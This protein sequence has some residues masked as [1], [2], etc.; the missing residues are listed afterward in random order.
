MHG[1]VLFEPP[2]PIQQII[3]LGV[4]V[5]L[6]A[7]VSYAFATGLPPGKRILLVLLRLLIIAGIVVVLCRPM[8]VKPA[9]ESGEKPVFTVLVDTSASM[10]TKDEG[11]ESRL[12]A[13]AAA[14]Q[15]A[16]GTFEGE[17]AQRYQVNFEEFSEEVRASSFDEIVRRETAAG[18]KT[19]IATALFGVSS[20]GPGKK[21][22]GV[23]LISD[24]RDNVGGEVE[25]V[26]AH[27]RSQK[28]PVW[29]TPVGSVTE[30]KD[31]YVTARLNQNF[32][33]V[34]QPANIKVELSQTGYKNWYAKVNL[35]REDKYVTT[36]QVNL[37]EGTTALDIPIKED[38]KGVFRYSVAV[39][40]L[41]GEADVKNNRRSVFVRVVDEKPK[42][43]LVEAEPYWDTRFLLRA[44][45]ADPNLEVSSLFQLNPT[46]V[47][48]IQ[49]KTS[50]DSLEKESVKTAF[51]M[52]RTKEDLYQYDC[53]ILG[54]GIDA[55][56]DSEELKLLRDY[57]MDRG[58]SIVFAR[59][60]SYSGDRPEIANIEP[61]VWDSQ[62]IKDV[63]FELTSEGRMNP[64]FTFDGKRAPD[65]VIRE[66]PS[67]VSVTKIQKEKSL[68][69]ILAKSKAGT[70]AQEMAVISYQRYGKGKVM[71]IGSAGLW[72]WAFMPESFEQYDDVYQLFWRQM[73]RWLIDESDF[74]PGQDISFRTDRYAY[75]LGEKVRF[76]I[77]AKHVLPAQYQPQITVKPLD[78]EPVKLIPARQEHDSEREMIYTAFHTPE[79][80]GEFEAVLTNNMG[81]PREDTA[82]FTVYSDSVET[83][84]VAA[85]R[86]LLAQAG[87][88]TGGGEIP[89]AGL[90]ELPSRVRQFEEL[91]RDKLKPRDIWDRLAV[92][93]LLAGLL[94]VEWFAR[95]RLGLV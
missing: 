35:Y 54:R 91:S 94:A 9:P 37:K 56:L 17:L 14:L 82:R 42:V 84:L 61:V 67:M 60:K 75:N 77:R 68:S 21:H 49:E 90:K 65:T 7:L 31:L 47:F 64:I 59:G 83:R 66:L 33:F 18:A 27:L 48:A 85:D 4:G 2:F 62:A 95:R 57:V 78:G 1:P 36:Q 40:P 28:I 79:S 71:S 11:Q 69:V 88:I 45:H 38:H 23:L 3:G 20:A 16:R 55:V 73:V 15:S 39:E 13:V 25:K 63:R 30:T 8:A 44:L 24:G 87:R 41:L 6:L 89:L 12:K 22:A 50:P 53:L 81:Q 10:N 5:L 93:S 26:A 74:L 80:E 29:T 70:N 92:F 58:G 32:S 86:D 46:K 19:D 51:S 34:K 72:R 76:V 52:P 43:L